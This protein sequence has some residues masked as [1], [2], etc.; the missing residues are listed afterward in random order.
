MSRAIRPIPA[1]GEL[2]LGKGIDHLPD[3]LGNQQLKTVG[4]DK[5]DHAG[6]VPPAIGFHVAKKGTVFL[7]QGLS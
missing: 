4:D 5:A 7:E 6:D 3:E 1:R 2:R